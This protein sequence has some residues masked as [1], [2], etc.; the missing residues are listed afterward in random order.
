MQKLLLILLFTSSKI[1]AQDTQIIYKADTIYF[2][3]YDFSYASVKTKHPI[4]NYVLP[5]IVY[6]SKRNP[7]A[8]F[9]AKMYMNVIHDFSYTNSVNIQFVE[10]LIPNQSKLLIAPTRASGYPLL[11][12]NPDTLSNQIKEQTYLN[13]ELISKFLSGYSL[14]QKTGIGLVAFLLEINKETESIVLHFVF[15]D[16]KSKEII[17]VYDFNVIGASGIGMKRHWGD[18]FSVGVQDFLDAYNFDL[19]KYYRSEYKR[20][21]KRMKKLRRKLKMD[22]VKN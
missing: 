4:N 20:K 11:F 21:K 2:Y 19:G 5:W 7:P 16:I 13:V 18:L 10:N 1:V 22:G 9:E 3:G 8:A 14:K 12:N 15:F 6:I 17:R